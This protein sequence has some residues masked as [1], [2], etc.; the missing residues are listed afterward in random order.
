MKIVSKRHR[1]SQLHES[2]ELPLPEIR[3]L[4]IDLSDFE[5]LIVSGATPEEI[6][7]AEEAIRELKRQLDA[8]QTV[9]N[10]GWFDLPP[11]Q[12]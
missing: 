11:Q 7:Q 2:T 12:P 1:Q 10:E 4:D 5:L 8:L 9:L 6:W 3:E